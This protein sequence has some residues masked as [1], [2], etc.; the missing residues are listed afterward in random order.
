ME[1]EEALPPP[2]SPMDPDNADNNNTKEPV[3]ID[4]ALDNVDAILS[5]E[6]ELDSITPNL[7]AQPMQ[8]HY[9]ANTDCGYQDRGGF[10]TGV[11]RFLDE[12][13]VQAE[14]VSCVN[15]CSLICTCNKKEN[16]AT[17]SLRKK[18]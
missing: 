7:A 12:A 1:T 15:V 6:L 9:L 18:M 4:D 8:L 14:M 2:P 10:A 13:S 3:T 16:I 11:G 5:L 17:I